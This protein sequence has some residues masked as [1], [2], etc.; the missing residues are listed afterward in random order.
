MIY[1][2]KDLIFSI[3]FNN[4]GRAYHILKNDF[5]YIDYQEAEEGNC[6]LHLAAFN[7]DLELVETIVAFGAKTDV[8]NFANLTPFSPTYHYKHSSQLD[9]FYFAIENNLL[10]KDDRLELLHL[11]LTN[12]QHLENHL[13]LILLD[14]MDSFEASFI[15]DN[16][17]GYKGKHSEIF[18]RIT[19]E[20]VIENKEVKTVSKKIKI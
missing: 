17:H 4:K 3:I 15:Y 19:F 16:L 13:M 8:K 20:L 9:V 11:I 12:E 1:K 14:G 18:E 10:G 6:A 5:A 7:N 2:E